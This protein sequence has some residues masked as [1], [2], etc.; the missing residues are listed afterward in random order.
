MIKA[1]AAQS[2]E[3]VAGV[4]QALEVQTA[5]VWQLCLFWQHQSFEG[6]LHETLDA[7][8]P[9]GTLL[10]HLQHSS[11]IDLGSEEFRHL[12]RWQADELKG[13]VEDIELASI[14]SQLGPDSHGP[15]YIGSLSD[16][17]YAAESSSCPYM[18]AAGQ[19]GGIMCVETRAL[20]MA[21]GRSLR[22]QSPADL[23]APHIVHEKAVMR[24]HLSEV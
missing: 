8:Q 22:G 18:C 14:G 24:P 21:T 13:R 23:K 10:E 2:S 17:M 7:S 16:A 12:R 6:C 15:G 19:I 11:A 3:K 9:I 20:I 1:L 4:D 5:V